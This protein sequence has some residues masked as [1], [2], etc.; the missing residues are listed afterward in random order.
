MHYRLALFSFVLTLPHYATPL[1]YTCTIMAPNNVHLRVW[2]V[3]WKEHLAHDRTWK[4]TPVELPASFIKY[5]FFRPWRPK[6]VYCNLHTYIRWNHQ[7]GRLAKPS[8]HIDRTCSSDFSPDQ[9]GRKGT[10]PPPV[11][12]SRLLIR[13]FLPSPS[14]L[15]SAQMGKTVEVSCGLCVVL[16]GIVFFRNSGSYLDVCLCR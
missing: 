11:Y 10:A 15:S 14:I 8:R 3:L 2:S 9:E 7:P 6:I 4:P 16:I 12:L 5:R 13:S 1:T